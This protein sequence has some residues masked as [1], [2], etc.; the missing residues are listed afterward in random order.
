[1]GKSSTT[2]NTSP[3]LLQGAAAAVMIACALIT[4]NAVKEPPVLLLDETREIALL[5]A[6]DTGLESQYTRCKAVL[7]NIGAILTA[8]YPFEDDARADRYLATWVADR[9]LHQA[10][11]QQRHQLRHRLPAFDFEVLLRTDKDQKIQIFRNGRRQGFVANVT[12]TVVSAET[13]AEVL[14]LSFDVHLVRTKVSIANPMG[15][16]LQRFK[17]L[18]PDFWEEPE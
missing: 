15:Y 3:M 2:P 5:S 7:V 17:S 11:L 10:I 12:Y 18:N 8:S 4:L 9:S 1:M 6:L 16:A 13:R 14:S